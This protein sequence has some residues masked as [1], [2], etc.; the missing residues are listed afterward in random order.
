VWTGGASE[1][2]DIKRKRGREME[3]E[4][5]EMEKYTHTHGCIGIHQT[6]RLR[7]HGPQPLSKEI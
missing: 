1:L 7:T 6:E 4:I 5:R 2:R 3:I